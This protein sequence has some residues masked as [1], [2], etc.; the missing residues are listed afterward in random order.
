MGVLLNNFFL[1]GGVLSTS[2]N[3]QAGGPPLV[4]C[5]GLLIQFIRSYLPYRRPFLYPQPVDA[6][7][8]GDGDPLHWGLLSPTSVILSVVQ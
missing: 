7:C 5:L 4:G 6:P 1:Q 2:P 8:R 3:P